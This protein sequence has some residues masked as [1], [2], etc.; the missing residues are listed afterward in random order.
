[1]GYHPEQP[2]AAAGLIDRLMES[3]DE[4]YFGLV[5]DVGHITA[6]GLDA[7]EIYKKYRS[8]MITTHLRDYDPNLE[9]ERNGQR[10]KGRFVPLGEGV[11][12]LRALIGFLRQ[13]KFAGQVMAEGGGLEASHDYMVHK[14]SLRL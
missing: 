9:Y 6:V 3:S 11:I 8:R 13:T 7:L 1:M 10:V 14:L 2:D 4:R 5:P 12:N